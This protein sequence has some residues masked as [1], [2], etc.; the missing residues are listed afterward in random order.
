M[1]DLTKH[2]VCWNSNIATAGYGIYS[3]VLLPTTTVDAAHHAN[4]DI[5]HIN[6]YLMPLSDLQ[7]S[8]QPYHLLARS[9]QWR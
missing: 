6:S 8:Q 1:Q 9:A 4:K 7:P 3:F 5:E 2:A